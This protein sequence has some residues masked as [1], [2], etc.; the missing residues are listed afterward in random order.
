MPIQ[1]PFFQD[2]DLALIADCVPFANPN[3]HADFLKDHAIAIACPK[4]DDG[5]AYVAKLAQ[6]F[7][8]NDIRSVKIVRMEVPCCGGLEHIAQLALEQSGKEI[9]LDSVIVRIQN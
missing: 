9:H 5:R 7:R 8:N 4:L 1:A 6:I 3:A 2:A